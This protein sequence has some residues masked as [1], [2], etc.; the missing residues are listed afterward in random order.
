[1]RVSTR[2]ARLVVGLAAAILVPILAIRLGQAVSLASENARWVDWSQS[3]SSRIEWTMTGVSD[4]AQ[5]EQAL[6]AGK[7]PGAARALRLG[8][9]QMRE[10]WHGQPPPPAGGAA[11]KAAI[12]DASQLMSEL[13]DQ[14]DQVIDLAVRG[15]RAQAL[16]SVADLQEGAMPGEVRDIVRRL[17]TLRQDT[18]AS[19]A[20]GQKRELSGA[21]WLAVI[22]G[23]AAILVLAVMV[24]IGVWPAFGAE[25]NRRRG[26]SGRAAFSADRVPAR[27]LDIIGHDLRQP[28]QAMGFFATALMRAP[29][30]AE[31]APLV[32][33]LRSSLKSMERMITGLLDMSKLDAGR[34]VPEPAEF[35]LADVLRPI[36]EEFAP[37]AAEKGI[38]LQ[39]SESADLAYT[40]PVLL[41]SI[42]RNI[43]GNAIKYTESGRVELRVEPDGQLLR[44]DI[45]DTGPG[46]PK[47]ELSRIFD[48][49]YRSS[50]HAKGAD[51]LGLGLAVARRLSALL[52]LA[53]RARSELG[54]GS[55]FSISVPRVNQIAFDAA[56]QPTP[57]PAAPA[58]KR[59]GVVPEADAAMRGMRLLVVDDDP[60]IHEALRAEMQR[61]GIAMTSAA[62]AEGALK[63]FA[64]TPPPDFDMLLVDFDLGDGDTGPE[65]LD[66]LAAQYGVA[67]PAL[68]MTG[69]TDPAVL[70]ELRDSGY[71]YVRKPVSI[72]TLIGRLAARRA[73]VLRPGVAASGTAMPGVPARP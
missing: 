33:G 16:A 63:L 32:A 8:A 29:G 21:F 10:L 23:E 66:Q 20:A 30:A 67:A 31:A 1:M 37:M 24:I 70:R 19:R 50:R 9:Q 39:V 11:V 26:A 56:W 35:R 4:I 42:L 40:D 27:L 41:E 28:L 34:F 44:I 14:A 69:T 2:I 48:E 65:L 47:E 64:A 68:V 36:R 6:L 51:G 62:S 54:A 7:Q 3:L 57:V 12:G 45:A 46:I 59:G 55:V 61:A 15:Q 25:D 71:P 17:I 72:A 5:K 49:F 53:L 52:G 22:A 43:V 18:W 60:S 73:D 38:V 13:A 58:R